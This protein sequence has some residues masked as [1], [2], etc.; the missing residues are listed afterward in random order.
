M[1]LNRQLSHIR[2][3]KNYYSKFNIWYRELG[4]AMLLICPTKTLIY[5]QQKE[6]VLVA[7]TYKETA[8]MKYFFNKLF[9][10]ILNKYIFFYYHMY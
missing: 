8:K 3:G 5:C 6:Y 9:Q 1:L 4:L 10:N 7:I 2:F